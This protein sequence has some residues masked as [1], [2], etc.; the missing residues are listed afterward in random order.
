VAPGKYTRW[1][2]PSQMTYGPIEDGSGNIREAPAAGAFLTLPF[3]GPHYVTSLFDHCGPNYNVSGR[4]CRYDGVVASS[5]VGGPDPGFGAGYAQTPGG[6]DYLY[7]SGHDGYDYGLYYEPVAAAAPGRVILANWLVP[8]CHT[9]LSGQTVEI[10]HGNGLMT[11][12]GHLA[13]IWVD[14]GQWVS[15]GQVIGIS[16]MTGTAT[17]PHLHF[18]VYHLNGDGPVDPYGWSGAGADPYSGDLG[19]LWLGGSPRFASITMPAVTVAAA[20]SPDAPGTIRVS[21]S[22]PGS[23]RF[24]VYL[25]S[26]DGTRRLW[27]SNMANGSA[28]YYGRAGQTYWFWAVAASPLGWQSGGGSIPVTV[29]HLNH[30][31]VS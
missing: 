14:K 19:D 17:G 10:D 5:R 1:A 22:S 21:W 23:M 4:I 29:A 16:G 11:F 6:H 28:T 25:V 9:C 27:R 26:Q 30:G 13:H 2:Y 24:N 3:M 15:R 7:Y 12:Y 31:E 18:G 8:G 20:T